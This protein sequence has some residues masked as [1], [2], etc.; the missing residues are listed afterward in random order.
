MI[1][2]PMTEGAVP[3]PDPGLLGTP[4]GWVTFGLAVVVGGWFLLSGVALAILLLVARLR[5]TPQVRAER[6]E[7]AARRM[8]KERWLDGEG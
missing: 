7:A 1:D 2:E 4:L 6:D 3:L 8:R 5:E